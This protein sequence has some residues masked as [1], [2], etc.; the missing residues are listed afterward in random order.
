MVYPS[1]EN[2]DHSYI[3]DLETPCGIEDYDSIFD[4]AVEN[5][6]QYIGHLGNAVYSDGNVDMFLNWN[7]DTGRCEDQTLTAWSK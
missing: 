6:T 1:K 3:K 4:R 2:I 5:I 7:L